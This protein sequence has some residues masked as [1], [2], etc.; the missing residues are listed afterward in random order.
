[1]GPRPGAN[2]ASWRGN[3]FKRVGK[4]RLPI[5]IQKGPSPWGVF[6]KREMT[7]QVEATANAELKKQVERRIRF[8]NLKKTGAV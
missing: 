8:I 1:M 7:K 5:Q 2:K 6:V 4:S 3:A